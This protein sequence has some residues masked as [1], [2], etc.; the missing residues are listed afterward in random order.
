MEEKKIERKE[1]QFKKDLLIL[2]AV[3][4]VFVVLSVYIS[5]DWSSFEVKIGTLA[6]NI[7]ALVLM[8][9]FILAGMGKVFYKIGTGPLYDCITDLERIKDRL[10]E[11]EQEFPGQAWKLFRED[12]TWEYAAPVMEQTIEKMDYETS[13]FEHTEDYQGNIADYIN[14]DLL[15]SVGNTD[16]NDFVSNVLTGLGILGTFVGLTIGLQS[17]DA[18]TAEAMTN[19][20]TPLIEGIKVAFFTSIFGV[21][22]SLIYGTMYRRC[23]K[24]GQNALNDFL[25]TFYKCQGSRPE[26]DVVSSVLRYEKEQCDVM[27]QLAEEISV[28]MGKILS[29]TLS[30]LPDELSQAVGAQLSPMVENMGKSLTEFTE[31]LSNQISTKQSEGVETLVEKFM[32]K[33]NEMTN[34]Q[35]ENLSRTIETIC[36]WQETT[37]KQLDEAV[38]GICKNAE[39]MSKINEELDNTVVRLENF[40]SGLQE[41]Q[42]K[43]QKTLMETAEAFTASNENVERT[44]NELAEISERSGEIMASVHKISDS[45]VQQEET[46]KQTV[47][48][49]QAK[50][51]EA[52]DLL[53][54]QV[55]ETKK[56]G[57]QLTGA[58]TDSASKMVSAS[59]NMDT[60][61]EAALDRSFKQ[62]DS[63]LAKALQHFSGTLTELQDVVEGAPQM[64]DDV[65]IQM[66]KSSAAYLKAVEDG[67]RKFGES[68]G[69]S[70]ADLA[71]QMQSAKAEE[72]RHEKQK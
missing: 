48:A 16:F 15:T 24:R 65:V 12:E 7:V 37:V 8:I 54:Q 68:V 49:Q 4:I 43:N 71:R 51:Q 27:S 10:N 57:E 72:A 18:E 61:L 56:T 29:P 30:A 14:E 47:E 1:N 25:D 32:D 19:S 50:L 46:L 39:N 20:I 36:T 5:V 2:I 11:L 26:D 59:Q 64:V 33:M 35:M 44:A 13:T 60:Q 6:V 53:N 55:E 63:Q 42:E 23:L 9:G 69:K 3:F 41:Y 28:E 58:L 22:F 38:S 52:A 21:T 31:R 40:L 67:Q 70:I 45:V 34:G 17:F 66:Q 62:F